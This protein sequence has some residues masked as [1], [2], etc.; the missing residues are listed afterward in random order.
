MVTDLGINGPEDL[1]LDYKVDN[2][3]TKAR[4]QPLRWNASFPEF[5]G[6]ILPSE[7]QDVYHF[8]VV[9]TSV[10]HYT[11]WHVLST[12]PNG[13]VRHAAAAVLNVAL[14]ASSTRTLRLIKDATVTSPGSWTQHPEVDFNNDTDYKID[15]II[16]DTYGNQY[17]C[18]LD[19]RDPREGWWEEQLV[20]SNDIVRVYMKRSGHYHATGSGSTVL[21]R[22]FLTMTYYRYVFSNSRFVFLEFRLG[23]DYLGDDNAPDYTDMAADPND[24]PLGPVGFSEWS[25]FHRNNIKVWFDAQNGLYIGGPTISGS[26]TSW[27]LAGTL[28][29]KF[30]GNFHDFEIDYLPFG[31]NIAR[32]AYLYYSTG[33]PTTAENDTWDAISNSNFNN[34]PIFVKTPRE[35]ANKTL[36][37][38][39]YRSKFEYEPWDLDPSYNRQ[40]AIS[41]EIQRFWNDG[42]FGFSGSAGFSGSRATMRWYEYTPQL[43][44][45]PGTPRGNMTGLMPFQLV[46]QTYL[47]TRVGYIIGLQSFVRPGKMMWKFKGTCRVAED[48]TFINILTGANTGFQAV[49]PPFTVNLGLKTKRISYS[50][51]RCRIVEGKLDRIYVDDFIARVTAFNFDGYTTEISAGTFV[52]GLRR[53]IIEGDTTPKII[54]GSASDEDGNYWQLASGQSYSGTPGESI[55]YTICNDPDPSFATTPS[56]DLRDYSKWRLGALHYKLMYQWDSEEAAHMSNTAPFESWQLTASYMLADGV[57]HHANIA[58]SFFKDQGN[59]D[60]FD[61]HRSNAWIFQAIH[62][63]IVCNTYRDPDLLRRSLDFIKYR[64]DERYHSSANRFGSQGT[65][66]EPGKPLVKDVIG[67]TPDS[68]W[69]RLNPTFYGE[70]LSPGVSTFSQKFGNTGFQHYE[71]W[72]GGFCIGNWWGL[73]IEVKDRLDPVVSNK[74]REVVENVTDFMSRYLLSPGDRTVHPRRATEFTY[75]SQYYPVTTP[76]RSRFFCY[77]HR[78]GYN[79]GPGNALDRLTSVVPGTSPLSSAWT[80]FMEVG[81]PLSPQPDIPELSGFPPAAYNESIYRS[82]LPPTVLHS[83]NQTGSAGPDGNTCWSILGIWMGWKYHTNN[84]SKIF[85]SDLLNEWCNV[86]AAQILFPNPNWPYR[87]NGQILYPDGL[88]STLRDY[89]KWVTPILADYPFPVGDVTTWWNSSWFRRRVINSDAESNAY[90]TEDVYSVTLDSTILNGS[91]AAGLADIRVILQRPDITFEEVPYRIMTNPENG[92]KK[93]YFRPVEDIP[94]STNIGTQSAYRYY[95]YYGNPSPPA[96]EQVFR[97]PG[98]LDGP[99]GPTDNT[100]F[101]WNQEGSLT[102]SISSTSINPNILPPPSG[103]PIVNDDGPFGGSFDFRSRGQ[104]IVTLATGRPAFTASNFTLD[105]WMFV[106]SATLATATDAYSIINR[107]GDN[108]PIFIRVQP[109]NANVAWSDTLHVDFN[110]GGTP[111]N[112]VL[113]S[114]EW[115]R[116]SWMHLGAVYDGTFFSVYVNGVLVRQTTASGSLVDSTDPVFTIG[117]L[118][119]TDLFKYNGKI[120]DV[121]FTTEAITYRKQSNP[122][123]LSFGSEQAIASSGGD[124]AITSKAAILEQGKVQALTSKTSIARTFEVC[125]RCITDLIISVAGSLTLESAV[126]ISQ[127]KDF[128]NPD[129]SPFVTKAFII[130]EEQAR[131]LNLT[132]EAY[133]QIQDSTQSLTSKVALQVPLNTESM[134]TKSAIRIDGKSQS[135]TTKSAINQLGKS[136]ILEKT[137]AA[138]QVDGKALEFTDKLAVQVKNKAFSLTNDLYIVRPNISNL[139]FSRMGIALT[140]ARNI[141]VKAAVQI[142]GIQNNLTTKARISSIGDFPLTSKAAISLANKIIVLS[143]SARV[144]TSVGKAFQIAAKAAIQISSN[145]QSLTNRLSITSSSS[146]VALSSSGVVQVPNNTLAVP[147]KMGVKVLDRTKDLPCHLNIQSA[148]EIRIISK[149]GVAVRN[150]ASKENKATIRIPNIP[151]R[152]LSRAYIAESFGVE[153]STTRRTLTGRT[154]RK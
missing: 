77:Y 35:T 26:N 122:A 13:N 91:L 104:A 2:Q 17:S 50:R 80:N 133:I 40:Q 103:L 4:V 148:G 75:L 84:E 79:G 90:T 54:I 45:D 108:L 67:S 7:L 110:I 92:Q 136:S 71:T 69:N 120:A 15:S 21:D 25:V 123:A 114:N 142:P 81:T 49:N 30:A 131:Q 24:Y 144:V 36:A 140:K 59:N 52:N 85:L 1:L 128:F 115:V 102:N 39:L 22:D 107:F 12:W 5:S 28:T 141:N 154:R 119:G 46:D 65:Y 60:R 113:A 126:A 145:E 74:M 143:S 138:I 100:A 68:D 132:S 150:Q 153:N 11:G 61:Q 63:G 72:Q 29:P 93:L 125:D 88:D 70:L 34:H 147:T 86:W 146:G 139:L 44:R 89:T 149:V 129:G 10:K 117:R 62:M 82:Y 42:N 76:T 32:H 111:A 33:T 112:I 118:S 124:L 6:G 16:K 27:S 43:T 20:E 105:F 95:I 41:A 101:I 109:A 151:F 99:V 106:Q 97:N 18:P 37:Y 134:T 38:S 116:N 51:A 19:D 152:I 137:N 14:P 98:S 66:S 53:L 9:E 55:R 121:R 64:F 8:Q 48:P 78:T 87:L 96:N 58:L 31:A 127:T 56:N 94:A 135:I 47:A 23:N 130:G 83:Y 57:S 3:S 73:Y